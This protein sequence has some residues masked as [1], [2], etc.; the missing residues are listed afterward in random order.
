[1]VNHITYDSYGNVIAQTHPTIATRFLFAGR[2][3]DAETGLYYDRARYYDPKLGRFLSEDPIRFLGG[4]NLYRYAHDNPVSRTD[5]RGTTDDNPD[6]EAVP[7]EDQPAPE[8]VPASDATTE[9]PTP[10]SVPPWDQTTELP[11]PEPLTDSF[12]PDEF[13]TAEW[14]PWND[15]PPTFIP[16]IDQTTQVP[17][18]DLISNTDETGL[19]PGSLLPVATGLLQAAE[20][21]ISY[22]G[23]L[24][25]DAA[26]AVAAAA[27][28]VAAPV[29]AFLFAFFVGESSAGEPGK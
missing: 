9:L 3:L 7:T 2:E 23:A 25:L 20:Q 29:G 27:A 1:V 6:G 14:S 5:P 15:E 18:P 10:E 13:A 11:T 21:T 22:Y 24:A 12:R 4:T 8:A 26:P 28:Q 16:D 19:G 17:I